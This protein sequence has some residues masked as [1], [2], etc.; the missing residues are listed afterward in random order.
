MQIKQKEKRGKIENKMPAV[1]L[2]LPWAPAI[3]YKDKESMKI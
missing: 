2:L 1:L 3:F